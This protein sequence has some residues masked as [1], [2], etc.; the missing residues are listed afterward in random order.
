MY[1][2]FLLFTFVLALSFKP[3]GL[4]QC[5]LLFA[6]GLMESNIRFRKSTKLSEFLIFKSKLSHS[7][8]VKRKQNFLKVFMLNIKMRNTFVCLVIHTCLQ[9][10][11]K[12]FGNLLCFY[13]SLIRQKA[14]RLVSTIM[15][16]I[17]VDSSTFS[18]NFL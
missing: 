12:D 5:K 6:E 1:Q 13:E 3:L 2:S 11:M 9:S 10:L 17:F 8:T 15:E 16:K 14:H 18:Y 4:W 7:I